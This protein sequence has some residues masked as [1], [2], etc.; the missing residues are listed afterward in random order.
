MDDNSQNP[1]RRGLLRE[2][3]RAVDEMQARLRALERSRS[4]PIAI[5]GMGCR[6]PGGV[7]SPESFWRLLRNGVDAISEVPADR[8]SSARYTELDPEFASTLPALRG[9]FLDH[10]DRFDPQFFGIAPREALSMDPQQRLALEVSWEALE[11]AG[12]DP[13][14]L[15]GSATGVFIGITGSDYWHHIRNADPKHLDVYIATGNAHNGAAGRISFV[16]GLQGPS[17]A[18]DTACSSSL[19]AIHLACQSLR[20]GE[21]NLALAGGVNTM[22][23]PDSFFGMFK[24]GMTAADGRCK[25]FDESA[26][27]F[28][29][30]EGCG[31][32][33]L[34]LLSDALKDGDRIAAVIR[35]S[36]MNQDGATSGFTVPNGFAQEAVIKQALRAAGVSPAD[37]SYV[38]AHGTG[39]SL[40]DPIELEALD[41]V[42]GNGRTSDNALIV[43][44]VKTNVGH[45]ESA[46]GVAGVMKVVLSLEHEEIPPHLHFTTLNSRASFRS[47]PPV[48]PVSGLPWRG[49]K[50]V[51][52]ISSFGISG[53]NLHV[54]V[55]S[56]PEQPAKNDVPVRPVEVVTLSAKSESALREQAGRWRQRLA[57]SRNISLADVARS[58]NAGRAHFTHRAAI[59]TSSID[60]MSGQLELIAR[61]DP[62][63]A[64]VR[65][66]VRGTER[67][68]V[69]FL[70]T[71]QGSQ[72]VGMA[73]ALYDGE[74]A[75]RRALD[76]CD[77]GLRPHLGTS[78]LSILYP[79]GSASS[80]IDETAF[81]QPA[82]FAVEYA[83][84]QMW[85]S[86]G[87]RP[88]VVLGH[89]VG[90]YVA[91][92]V[93]G[94]FSLEDAARLIAARARLMQELPRGGAMA[95]VLADC[96]RVQ[97]AITREGAAVSI[98]A[99]NGPAQVTIAGSAS[100]VARVVAALDR[101]GVRTVPLSVSHA[102][103]SA[104]LDPMLNALEREA[105]TVRFSEPRIPVISNLSGRRAAAGELTS[106]SYWRRHARETVRFRQ[107]IEAAY[108][109]GCTV[110]LEIGPAATLIGLGRTV[111]S[112]EA[113]WLPSLR[114]DGDAWATVMPSLADLHV[115]GVEIDWR[116]IAA[117]TAGRPV[118]LPTYPF[119]RQR[120][121][122]DAKQ[123][124]G[125][126]DGWKEWLYDLEWKPRATDASVRSPL[127]LSPVSSLVS[128]VGGAIDALSRQHRFD[129]HASMQ[130][131]LEK[132][133]SA[134]A[135]RAV[136]SLAGPHS[137]GASFSIDELKA[138]GQVAEKHSR[139]LGRLLEILVEDGVLAATG[140]RWEVRR[141]LDSTEPSAW[142][143][144]LQRQYPEHDAEV[145][146]TAKCGGQL[147]EVMAGRT[148][149]MELLFPGG[150]FE[151]LE[152]IYRDA[153]GSRVYNLLIQQT[154]RTALE[155]TPRGRRVRVLEIGAGTGST[156]GFVIPALDPARATYTF[157]DV[158]NAFLDRA[159]ERFQ[160]YDFVDYRLLDISQPPEAQGFEPHSFDIII[161]SHV[162]H[163]TPDIRRTLAHVNRLL[164]SEGVVILFETTI[165]PRFLDLTFGMTDGWWSYTDTD[166]RTSH[167][168]LSS[169]QWMHAL[170]ESGCEDASAAGEFVGGSNAGAALIFGRGPE[171]PVESAR[172]VGDWLI[173]SDA[174]GLG[175]ELAAQIAGRGGRALLAE[176]HDRFEEISSSRFLVDAR[177]PEQYRRVIAAAVKRGFDLRGIVH[178]WSLGSEWAADADANA[179]DRALQQSS[180]SALLL[181]QAVLAAGLEHLPRL[182]LV[183]RGAQA[184][185]SDAHEIAPGAGMLWGLS[186]SIAREHPELRCTAVDLDARGEGAAGLVDAVLT[187]GSNEDQIALRDGER[188]VL[189][190]E[191]S[192]TR[193][194]APSTAPLCR[195]EG[196]YLVTG[197]LSGVG[198][199]AARRLVDQGARRIVLMGRS[200][201][202][203][204]TRRDIESMA[205]S[206]A[207]IE[208]VRGSVADRAAIDRA[209][210]T[211]ESTGLPLAGIVHSAGTL[212]D[213]MLQQQTW[214]RF[215]TVMEA[216]VQGAWNLHAAAG[217]RALDFFVLFSSTAAVL[218]PAGQSNHAAVNAFLDSLA[219]HRRSRGLTGL[220]INWG[221]WSGIGAAVRVGTVDRARTHG[222][223]SIDP[224]SGA[225]AFEHL[226]RSGSSQT[227]VLP[228]DWVTLRTTYAGNQDPPL[229]R[230]LPRRAVKQAAAIAATGSRAAVLKEQLEAAPLHQ[231]WPLLLAHVS[232]QAAQ[233][234]GLD[235]ATPL[236]PAQG[237]RD[238]GLDSLMALELRNRLQQSAGKSLRSTLAFDFPTIDAV[239]RHLAHDVL[240]VDLG[241][242]STADAA[243]AFADEAPLDPDDLLMQIEQLSDEQ[244]ERLLTMPEVE[245]ERTR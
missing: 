34:K 85:Q 159:A 184:I 211:A 28:V 42:L 15:G 18:I 12:Y 35:G 208:I 174:G 216:K 202:T 134:Y 112:E 155:A 72:Y 89:S 119:E 231:R 189:R 59:V 205:A 2:A 177:D 212:D 98:A 196:S 40:G 77:A 143:A 1:D 31:V 167:P 188:L 48:V 185:G 209:V 193:S 226:L 204:D 228:A 76:E 67:P 146:L 79:E 123:T 203:G 92:C 124:S 61:G 66:V 111:I 244:A 13:T 105:R 239:A 240:V 6:F 131:G 8:W 55:E 100:D 101:D 104:L 180:G 108:E 126:T 29:R 152:R 110:F 21:S 133:C 115:R 128:G 206:G 75:F 219:H 57:G 194:V 17:L 154:V 95:A 149:P 10:V 166:L 91:A 197:G 163:A 150:S 139:L 137:V 109:Q 210:S 218:G 86:W 78:V 234:L 83:L 96:A 45:L 153:P 225:A 82:L 215:R 37:V 178:L 114:R 224:E 26:D 120:F 195:A 64:V 242:R 93:A 7:D 87:V 68:R 135:S 32:L 229:L 198:L 173:L 161:A 11:D 49:E 168:L 118:A 56:A 171:R 69:A 88:S 140:S 14:A 33:I 170:A 145:A 52:G 24:W 238:L 9:G 176:P 156:A 213:G 36:A 214:D 3:L 113:A 97:A 222:V 27:G 84:A 103:H 183:T 230:D 71:G 186:R 201:P 81:T 90:E 199:L 130:A 22:H 23:D 30:S 41:A 62:S 151:Q 125:A 80:R 192:A 232:E 141:A 241:E 200:E 44:S 5:V 162:L 191:P 187:D 122:I 43:G 53:T 127:N 4:E 147:A 181:A 132:L 220:S 102:F 165:R 25:T 58:A 221:P 70:F 129:T 106:A 16:L 169:A 179:I 158:S 207:A 73:R 46:A 47:V 65:G 227:A 243:A 20:L 190:L 63:P 223:G 121:W 175:S 236:D 172:S 116:A 233:V 142:A 138:T 94:V 50:R 157:T 245:T 19:A 74:P 148:N 117:G 235:P 160:S 99:D 237:L 136:A 144:D 39:T 107:G 60:E 38:E 182:V 164:A 54:I 51:A 217:S